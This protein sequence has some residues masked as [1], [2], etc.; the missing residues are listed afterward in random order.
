[1]ANAKNPKRELHLN[2]FLMTVGHH[3]SAWRFPESS[4]L[5]AWDVQ[6]YVHLAREA[7]RGTFD[8]IF[9]GDGPALVRL[10]GGRGH[11]TFSGTPEQVAD[12]IGEWFTSGA[13][14]GFNIMPPLL[15]SGLGEFVEHVVPVLRRRGLFRSEYSGRTLREHYGLPR[16]DNRY[17]SGATRS[18]ALGAS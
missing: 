13:A 8:S 3:E 1:M 10:G 4:L 18:V 16:P 7:E 5:G 12:T 14:D 2:A 6:H 11:R 17:T 9:F 15:P